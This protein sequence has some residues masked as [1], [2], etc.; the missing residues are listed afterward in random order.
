M[1]TPT[2]IVLKAL[3]QGLQISDHFF[4]PRS[5]L[6]RK[7]LAHSSTARIMKYRQLRDI[8]PR[9]I[10]ESMVTKFAIDSK[11]YPKIRLPFRYPNLTINY[12]EY[13]Y[14]C[15]GLFDLFVKRVPEEYPAS[16]DH[17][18]SRKF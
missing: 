4:G 7:S 16:C 6:V 9:S 3:Q 2:F 14:I 13:M 17:C 8:P 15:Q 5:P 12:I 11:T 10:L 1:V 18:I